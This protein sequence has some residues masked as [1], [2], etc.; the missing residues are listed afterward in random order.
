MPGSRKPGPLLLF[1]PQVVRSHT[2]NLVL[3]AS[4]AL[5]P[6]HR[7]ERPTGWLSQGTVGIL[8]LGL[9]FIRFCLPGPAQHRGQG[10][11]GA[12]VS[13]RLARQL[14]RACGHLLGDA[15]THTNTSTRPHRGT[16]AVGRKWHCRRALILRVEAQ[17]G[18]V[19]HVHRGLWPDTVPVHPHPSLWFLSLFQEDQLQPRLRSDRV[20]AGT[21]GASVFWTQSPSFFSV[22]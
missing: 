8:K 1:A 2:L 22:P 5:I 14:S 4:R 9:C 20:W 17:T 12:A 7:D 19:T 21:T 13:R 3:L 15:P 18:Q 6:L 16:Q 10:H 11:A